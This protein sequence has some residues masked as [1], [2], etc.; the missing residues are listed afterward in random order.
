MSGGD[1]DRPVDRHDDETDG[2]LLGVAAAA[3][4]RQRMPSS[5]QGGKE[6]RG[7][8]SKDCR[9][10]RVRW[11]ELKGVEIGGRQWRKRTITQCA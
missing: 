11:L 6:R 9:S 2:R 4:Q 5:R 1:G 3:T 7:D 8:A 10:V